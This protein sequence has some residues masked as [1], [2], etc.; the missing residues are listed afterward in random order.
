MMLAVQ[1]IIGQ[2]N[3]PV[4]QLMSFFYSVQDVKI[5]LERINEIHNVD[6]ENG[7]QGQKTA[8]EEKNEGIEMKDID[9]KYDPHADCIVTCKILTIRNL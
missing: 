2:L 8:V 4:E 6:D 9:F 3:A 1:Y 5:S 7:K